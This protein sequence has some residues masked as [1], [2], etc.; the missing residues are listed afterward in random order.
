MR[1]LGKTILILFAGAIFARMGHWEMAAQ[2]KRSTKS[3]LLLPF[4]ITRLMARK[5]DRRLSM[6]LQNVRVKQISDTWGAD[7]SAGRKHE[8]QDIFAPY[9]TPVYSATS[10]VVLRIVEEGI[11]G[12]T[13]SVIGDGGRTYYYAHLS[14]F[15]GG[16]S[17]GD[18]V[19][20]ETVL[21]YVGNTGNARFS[22]PH[23]HFAVYGRNGG[24]DPLP[25]LTDRG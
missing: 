15:A 6:P 16:L 13:V 20:R 3:R 10:G 21:G 8:G 1:T 2:G 23:L 18:E 5:P 22:R 19:T 11:G 14:A 9:G 17:V 7:R 4:K 25:L 24:I 12:K